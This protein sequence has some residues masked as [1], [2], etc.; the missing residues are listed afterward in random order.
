MRKLLIGLAACGLFLVA[1]PAMAANAT[2][3]G[4]ITRAADSTAIVGLAVYAKNTTTGIDTF[5]SFTTDAAGAYS[6]SVPAGTYDITTYTNTSSESGV[7]FV[8]KTLTVSVATDQILP[9]QNFVLSRRGKFTGH[10]Y[11]ADG[12]TPILGAYVYV[13]GTSGN[14]TTYTT[15]SGAYN[16]TP[17]LYGSNMSS[18]VGSYNFTISKTG[19]ISASVS[20]VALTADDA[21]TTL[22]VR[23][24]PAST[25]TGTITDTNG[26]ALAGA[27]VTVT[28]SNGTQYSA[29]TNAVGTYTISINDPQG[30]NGTAIADYTMT[31]VKT[32]YVSRTGRLSITA[33]GSAVT[34]QDFTMT[35]GKVYS[36][37]VVIKS[38]GAA[39]A[40]ATVSLYNRNKTRTTL[41]D[42]TYTTGSDGS[43]SFSSLPSGKYRIVVARSGYA[44]SVQD[45][46]SITS[47]RTG[48][49]YQL[50]LGGSV[51]GLIY[52]GKSTPINGAY[53]GVYSIKNGK[54]MAFTSTTADETGNY[55]V[56]GLRR[57]TYK[58]HIITTDYVQTI[59]TI[60]VK[61]TTAVT[62]N[63]KLAAAG[64]VSGYLT[65]K[66]TG[67]PISGSP[68]ST[69]VTVKVIGTSITATPDSNG[70][71]ILD[72]IAPGTRKITVTGSNY[73]L[74]KQVTVK[75]SANKIKTSVNFSLVPRQ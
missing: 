39:L 44:M 42:F 3:S 66:V 7:I 73:E 56:T 36:G 62:K 30:Y 35:V 72:G 46:V 51:K 31:V 19:F 63:I 15:S 22:D 59:A 23:L 18:A 48:I 68:F 13:S 2:I 33:D 58:L 49:S 50:E 8:T 75:V 34:G 40:G 25:V 47:N 5:S 43:F 24:V 55:L 69:S 11:A 4:T 67:L 32:G 27:I 65:D 61:N 29:L 38:S 54:E 1:A 26:A 52:T 64:S 17:Y 60:T 74:P 37:T 57:G 70:Y 6:I 53:V 20:N 12:V 21:N 9:G 10:V 71:Y 45:V 14:G 41:A 28:K 16:L